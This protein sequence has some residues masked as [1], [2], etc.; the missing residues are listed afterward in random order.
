MGITLRDATTGERISGL[1]GS[2]LF[3]DSGES[4]VSSG[5]LSTDAVRGAI[6]AFTRFEQGLDAF[7]D[8]FARDLEGSLKDVAQP[9]TAFD[10]QAFARGVCGLSNGSPTRQGFTEAAQTFL[11]LDRSGLTAT[12]TAEARSRIA[13]SIAQGQQA[14][15]AEQVQAAIQA[16]ASMQAG[17]DCMPA[18][19]AAPDQSQKVAMR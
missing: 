19:S 10:A 1:S 11:M 6:D 18:P 15:T 3:V 13:S 14:L 7:R 9:G 4:S 12:E 16:M 2:T 5:R 17:G 8:S